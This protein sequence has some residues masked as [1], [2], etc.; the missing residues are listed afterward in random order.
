MKEPPTE[1]GALPLWLTFAALLS[2]AALSGYLAT[3]SLGE[4][5]GIACSL[6]IASTKVALIAIVFMDLRELRGGARL[7]AIAAPMFVAILI[8][9]M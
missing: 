3:R 6:G 1:R 7:A 4:G 8:L 9:L 2:L 5:L